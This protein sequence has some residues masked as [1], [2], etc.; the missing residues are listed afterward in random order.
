MERNEIIQRIRTI[1]VSVLKHEDFEMKEGLT[2]AEVEGWDSLSHMMI[3]T[4]IETEFSIRFKL[5]D[6]N[7]LQ[8]LHSL[9]E[10]IQSKVNQA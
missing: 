9:I 6:L 8:N 4:A 5:K 10:L 2:A 7:K 1:L 3:V